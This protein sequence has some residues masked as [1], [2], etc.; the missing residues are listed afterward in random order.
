G[1]GEG[2]GAECAG[3][4]AGSGRDIDITKARL[5]E[6]AGVRAAIQGHATAEAEILQSCL[7]LK[8]AREVDQGFFQH[9]LN[10]GGDVGVSPAVVR[11]QIDRV[12][13]V[14]GRSEL[15]DE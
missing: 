2:G 9:S 14:A 7:A 10:A 1:C 13:R 11:R 6:D 8:R 5:S 3:G 15:R 12:E 4:G